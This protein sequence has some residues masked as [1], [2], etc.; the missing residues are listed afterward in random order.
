MVAS[1]APH[2]RWPEGSPTRVPTARASSLGSRLRVER[3]VIVFLASPAVCCALVRGC[4]L[5]RV[6][7]R[8]AIRPM[9]ASPSETTS[10]QN[11]CRQPSDQ[12]PRGGI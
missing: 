7:G 12:V 11:A 4:E 3:L 9:S 5:R 6:E 1:S 8:N 2:R 10:L